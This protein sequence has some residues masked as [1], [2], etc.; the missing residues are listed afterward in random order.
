MLR[1]IKGQSTLEYAM[2]I[3][4]VVGG[5]IAMQYYMKRGIQGKLR[6][7]SDSIGEQYSAGNITSKFTIEQTGEQISKETFG[8]NPDG[9]STGDIA[10]AT[11]V[12]RYEI[13]TA[14]TIHRTATVDDAEKITKTFEQETLFSDE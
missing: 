5:L 8:M 9:T 14:A 2:I 13:D 12:S 7:S 4:V 6:E 1:K 10:P 11:G 3:A